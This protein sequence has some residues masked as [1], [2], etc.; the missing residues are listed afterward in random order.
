MGKRSSG[1]LKG[2]QRDH[3]MVAKDVGRDDRYE[4]LLSRLSHVSSNSLMESLI[5]LQ[6]NNFYVNRTTAGFGQ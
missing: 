6:N 5:F 4:M 3:N 2:C 1:V